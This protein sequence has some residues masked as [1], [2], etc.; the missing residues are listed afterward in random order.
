MRKQ[1]KARAKLRTARGAAP[2]RF[3]QTT[4]FNLQGT[5]LESISNDRPPSYR[6]N[7]H[8]GWFEIAVSMVTSVHVDT[9]GLE[10]MIAMQK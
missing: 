8:D 4:G 5:R 3:F 2:L 1:K 9:H 7:I 10:P 6:P